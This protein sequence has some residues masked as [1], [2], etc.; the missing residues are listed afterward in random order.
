MTNIHG[1]HIEWHLYRNIRIT[2][3]EAAHCHIWKLLKDE[4][5]NED[6]D[7]NIDGFIVMDS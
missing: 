7:I 4:L 5:G 2:L 3:I 1:I 6:G